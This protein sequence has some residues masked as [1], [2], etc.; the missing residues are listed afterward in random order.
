[1]REMPFETEDILQPLRLCRR[2]ANKI[3]VLAPLNSF[4]RA[5]DKALEDLRG[6][7]VLMASSHALGCRHI[8]ADGTRWSRALQ[9]AYCEHA[10]LHSFLNISS[11]RARL[12]TFKLIVG[13]LKEVRW[14]WHGKV[15]ILSPCSDEGT[16]AL[17]QGLSAGVHMTTFPVH[18]PL[19]QAKIGC[20]CC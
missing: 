7:C 13:V 20:A 3:L 9:C 10:T 17:L 6:G 15:I 16:A 11:S 2:C 12:Q 18:V 19:R 14:R 4:S 8:S 1:M 5:I